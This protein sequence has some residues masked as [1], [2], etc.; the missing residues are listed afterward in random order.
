MAE[1][2]PDKRGGAWLVSVSSS[3]SGVRVGVWGRLERAMVLIGFRWAD[4][5]VSCEYLAPW[6]D[7]FN[8]EASGERLAGPRNTS[9]RLRIWEAEALLSSMD[10]I[11][12]DDSVPG[13]SDRVADSKSAALGDMGD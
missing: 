2:E 11:A 5:V 7:L 4:R 10:W 6:V 8:G 3:G 1:D 13:S 9:E 12:A